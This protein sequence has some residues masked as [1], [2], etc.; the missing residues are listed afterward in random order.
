MW[1]IHSIYFRFLQKANK[2]IFYANGLILMWTVAIPFV[3]RIMAEYFLNKSAGTAIVIYTSFGPFIAL[4]YFWLI[5]AIYRAKRLH[6]PLK[7]FSELKKVR[8]KSAL[9]PFAY[10]GAFALAFFYPYPALVINVGINCYW[11]FTKLEFDED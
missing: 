2:E 6:N 1:Y 9:G 3:N 11:A 4:S 5:S 7:T 8:N 10:A